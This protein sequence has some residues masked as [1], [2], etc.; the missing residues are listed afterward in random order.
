MAVGFS[1]SADVYENIFIEVHRGYGHQ[2]YYLKYQ[3]APQKWNAFSILIFISCSPSPIVVLHG[4][5]RTTTPSALGT[6]ETC[7]TVIPTPVTDPSN[8]I[9]L[10]KGLESIV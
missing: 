1:F 2:E 5:H 8:I 9:A 3:I 7:L 10:T 4:S 6:V